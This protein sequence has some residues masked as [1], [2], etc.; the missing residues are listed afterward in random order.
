M[1]GRS[2]S[3]ARDL[4]AGAIAE[5]S[6]VDSASTDERPSARDAI[7]DVVTDHPSTPGRIT[8]AALAA[9]ETR[10]GRPQ[11]NDSRTAFG[12]PSHREASTVKSAA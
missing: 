2:N 11:A 7:S 10:A 6:A 12:V 4:H 8:P 5:S 9:S 1:D 3:A